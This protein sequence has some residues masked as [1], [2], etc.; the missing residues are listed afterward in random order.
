M[1]GE[2]ARSRGK[3]LHMAMTV[4]AEM[5]FKSVG[6]LAYND[7]SFW[8]ILA[9]VTVWRQITYVLWRS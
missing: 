8:H 7:C 6:I 4:L 9:C 3:H 2:H 1:I 5:G